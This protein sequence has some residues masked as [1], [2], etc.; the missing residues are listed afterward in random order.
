MQVAI[1]EKS[2]G[3]PSKAG[4]FESK[5]LTGETIGSV[6][7]QQNTKSGDSSSKKNPSKTL[8]SKSQIIASRKK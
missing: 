4:I 8:A 6:T 3:E 7:A 2:I 1:N 5:A